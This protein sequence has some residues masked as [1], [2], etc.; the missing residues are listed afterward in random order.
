MCGQ[1]RGSGRKRGRKCYCRNTND[2]LNTNI[3]QQQQQQRQQQRH[4]SRLPRQK[5]VRLGGQHGRL[6]TL[7]CPATL[8]CL[9]SPHACKCALLRNH[10]PVLCWGLLGCGGGCVMGMAMRQRLRCSALLWRRFLLLFVAV[11][12]WDAVKG[13]RP[14]FMVYPRGTGGGTV[15]GKKKKGGA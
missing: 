12:S 4:Q 3:P 11:Q 15:G 6:L 14:G 9:A 10:E 1:G 13:L 7:A 5:P 2:N 8:A